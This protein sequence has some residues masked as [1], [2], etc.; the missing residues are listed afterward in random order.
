MVDPPRT[1]SARRH[2]A[3]FLTKLLCH[4]RSS[5]CPTR[6]PIVAP[7]LTDRVAH[8]RY[9]VAALECYACHS[10]DF[11]TMNVV[12]PEKSVGFMGGGNPTLDLQGNTIRT[13]N[14]T[15]DDETGIGR[16]T[17]Q[18]LRR[19][20]QRPAPR[21]LADSL[22][23]GADAPARATTRSGRSTPTSGAS[24]RSTTP[25]PERASHRRALPVPETE[26]KRLFARYGC[27]SC[28]GQDGVGIGDLRHAGEHFPTRETLKFWIQE[29][30]S[31]RP[32]TRMPAW[33]DVIREQDYDPLINHVLK[34]GKTRS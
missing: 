6:Q 25:C 32:G 26:G 9:L 13:A 24:R 23:D 33:K 8:G 21:W 7:P 5:R 31:I 14:L 28:H 15:A 19:A 16:W 22:S 34:L 11:K 30:P 29:A 20:L 18:D 1:A 2:P 4:G 27:V 3:D 17:E 10:A 12:E